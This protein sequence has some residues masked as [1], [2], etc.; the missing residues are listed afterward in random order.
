MLCVRSCGSCR[1]AGDL[2]P[3]EMANSECLAFD[4]TALH[5]EHLPQ[6]LGS[7][8]SSVLSRTEWV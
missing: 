7:S 8:V 5:S 1:Q 4:H 6:D 2:L 3:G